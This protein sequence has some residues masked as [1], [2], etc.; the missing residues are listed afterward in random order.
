[1]TRGRRRLMGSSRNPKQVD[2]YHIDRSSGLTRVPL[3]GVP[4]PKS[5]QS[6]TFSPPRDNRS[7]HSDVKGYPS[8]QF[9]KAEATAIK[10]SKLMLDTLPSLKTNSF[11]MMH[12]ITYTDLF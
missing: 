1:M 11:M 10:V 2:P 4:L 7:T 6:G 12:I 5:I 8:R 3:P 9:V